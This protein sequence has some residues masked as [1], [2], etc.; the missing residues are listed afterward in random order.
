M[1]IDDFH[2]APQKMERSP[3]YVG[4]LRSLIEHSGWYSENQNSFVYLPNCFLGAAL[5]FIEDKYDADMRMK[6]STIRK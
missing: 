1:L 3:T 4:A 5:S 2:M 6:I